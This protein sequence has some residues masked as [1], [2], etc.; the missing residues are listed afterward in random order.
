MQ[1]LYVHYY[2]VRRRAYGPL[3]CVAWCVM[4]ALIMAQSRAESTREINN[5]GK[6]INPFP[7]NAIKSIRQYEKINKKIWRSLNKFPDFFVWAFLLRVQTWN[8]SPLQSNLLRMQCTCCTIPTPSGRSHWNPLVCA[9]QW[10][11]SQ[12]LPSPHLFHNDSL[13]A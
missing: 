3:Q 5:Y 8:S 6:Y 12:P 13:W 4:V 7:P 11:S 1:P 10:P 2:F 9:C